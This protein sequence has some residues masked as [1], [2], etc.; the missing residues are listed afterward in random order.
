MRRDRASHSSTSTI[1]FFFVS[2]VSRSSVPRSQPTLL[3]T[4]F[5]CSPVEDPPAETLFSML[6]ILNIVVSW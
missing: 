6:T 5:G 2:G 3:R 4:S 1:I